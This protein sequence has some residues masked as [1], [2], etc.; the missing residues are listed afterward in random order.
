VRGVTLEALRA[1][2]T[3]VLV[4]HAKRNWLGW[5]RTVAKVR[6]KSVPDTMTKTQSTQTTTSTAPVK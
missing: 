4:S 5:F 6:V 3:S 2:L 1:F